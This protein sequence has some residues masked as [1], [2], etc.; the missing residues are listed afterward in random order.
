MAVV[1]ELL[2]E[3]G[4]DALSFGDYT[5][6]EK[7]KLEDKFLG[8]TYKVK[9]HKEITR[10]E[11]NGEFVYESIPGTAVVGFKGDAT[12]ASFNVEGPSDAQI[13]LGFEPE[14][15]YKVTVNGKEAGVIKT[16]LG[17]KLSFGVEL[18]AGKET[19]VEVEK[20]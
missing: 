2:R 7:A 14:T 6:P 4:N 13:T 19:K 3:E 11:K 16:N 12:S 8:E 5:L 17:G 1:S 10:L 18:D 9:T 15:E 20:A